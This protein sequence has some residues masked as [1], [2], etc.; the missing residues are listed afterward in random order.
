MA[1]RVPKSREQQATPDVSYFSWESKG[2]G[3][4][5]SS[6]ADVLSSVQLAIQ[7]YLADL[8]LPDGRFAVINP[9]FRLDTPKL[10]ANH[11]LQ[12]AIQQSIADR[13]I[14]WADDD[15]VHG[16]VWGS[17]D[18]DLTKNAMRLADG[19]ASG[20]RQLESFQQPPLEP[21]GI[22]QPTSDK[23]GDS[24]LDQASLE[25][26]DEAIV[27]ENSV[28]QCRVRWQ[29]SF[30]QVAREVGNR[31][32]SKSLIPHAIAETFRCAADEEILE[33]MQ[34]LDSSQRDRIYKSVHQAQVKEFTKIIFGRSKPKPSLL[35][36]WL[37]KNAGTQFGDESKPAIAKAISFFR[38][39]FDVALRYVGDDRLDRPK[40]TLTTQTRA[41]R[42]TRFVVRS[43]G[44]SQVALAYRKA[45]PQLTID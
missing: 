17:V 16:I 25:G 35:R 32:T 10:V 37:H 40:C 41:R 21:S 42:G 9:S 2:G 34:L 18:D 15:G 29:G 20:S 28:A 11:P 22:W 31:L 23:Q 39:E 27:N 4:L 7:T 24:L 3:R 36:K 33:A 8:Q 44:E 38:G 12:G 14:A 6:G 30:E 45:F 19:I 26:G 1:V 5:K 13:E 43:S